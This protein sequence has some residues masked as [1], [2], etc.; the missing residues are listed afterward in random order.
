MKKVLFLMFLLLLIGLGAAS[1]KAQV[2]IG[3]NGAPNAAA[4]LDLNATDEATPAGN[5]GALALPRV[6]LASTS[7]QLN[8][9]TPIN[10]MLVY[11]TGGS[12]TAG[13]YFYNG[14][15]W[16]PISGDG[17]IGNEL[18]DTIP[19]GGLTKSGSGTATDPFKVGIKAG[20]ITNTMIANM[21][22]TGQKIATVPADSGK[23]LISNGITWY[24]S[25]LNSTGIS[26]TSPYSATPVGTVTWTKVFDHV[27][28][29]TVT[30]NKYVL[31]SIPGLTPGD[32]CYDM[33]TQ[34]FGTYTAYTNTLYI[35]PTMTGSGQNTVNPRLVCFRPS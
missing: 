21:A 10:G 32:L 16:L 30:S 2:R 25:G 19:G 18:T 11:N 23:F 4:V 6:S 13:I 14:S 34:T 9:T 26:A 35:M 20:G 31:V 22:V 12:L 27:V 7:A 1:V 15:N 28:S 8:G 5:K 29:I 3:G 17:I 24:A 33:S